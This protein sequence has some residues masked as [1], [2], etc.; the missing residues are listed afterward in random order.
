MG[1]WCILNPPDIRI[2]KEGYESVEYTK[3]IEKSF[4]HATAHILVDASVFFAFSL[5][6]PNVPEEENLAKRGFKYRD[7]MIVLIPKPSSQTNNKLKK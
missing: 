1:W 5:I 7:D 3:T 2:E 6:L 4:M